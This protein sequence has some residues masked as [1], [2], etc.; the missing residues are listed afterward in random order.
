[1]PQARKYQ[2]APEVTPYY[3]CISRC[4]R[5]AF[6]CGYDRLTERS[7]EHRRQWIVDRLKA[8]VQAFAVDICAYA[9]MNNHFHLVIKIQREQALDWSRDEVIERWTQ[10]F[11]TP[12]LVARYQS[13]ERLSSAEEEALVTLTETWR[14]RLHSLSWFMRAL[15]EP[16]ARM[17]NQ[18]DGCTGRFWEGRFTSQ[19]LLDEA[20]LLTAMAYVDLNPVRAGLAETPETSDFTSIQARIQTLTVEHGPVTVEQVERPA[21]QPFQDSP[22]NAQTIPFN[23]SDYL[24]LVDWTGRAVRPDKRGAISSQQP[25][26][27]IRLG[28][29]AR[30][31]IRHMKPRPHSGFHRVIGKLDRIKHAAENFGM[32]FFKGQAYA[33]KLFSTT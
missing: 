31:F 15:N 25:P 32:K 9:I 17:A 29:D 5:R 19:A 16:I 20:A 11:S 7:F 10:L 1:M 22:A 2:V 21:L 26:I 24:E 18:E 6:L 33:A 13:G 4:V 8:L 30:Q 14:E 12:Y 23:F 28:I 27:L 3:H